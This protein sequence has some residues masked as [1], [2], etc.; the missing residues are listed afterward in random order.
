MTAGSGFILTVGLL[1]S[2][3]LAGCGD[4]AEQNG[5]G[6][7]AQEEQQA[8]QQKAEPK[9]KRPTRDP[10]ADLPPRS[11]DIEGCMPAP[12]E[13]AERVERRLIDDAVSV[14]LAY[15]TDDEKGRTPTGFPRRIGTREAR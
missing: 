8:Q 5:T 12:V 6:S 14:R 9:V 2:L 10:S 1:S 7:A 13:L 4:E 3:V 11:V 15:V